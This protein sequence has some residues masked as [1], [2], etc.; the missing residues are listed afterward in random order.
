[1]MVEATVTDLRAQDAREDDPG[2]SEQLDA[3]RR[4]LEELAEEDR[5]P[6]EEELF[7]LGS[8]EGDQVKPGQTIKRAQ[9]V[10][11]TVS[12]SRAE[13]PLR[14]SGMLDPD[15]HGRVLVTYLPGKDERVPKRE[16]D[17]SDRVT[18]W[19]I[20]QNLRATYVQAANDAETMIRLFYEELLADDEKAAKKLLADLAGQES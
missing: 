14:G 11:L 8:L 15:K 10:E 6:T 13:V 19:K 12:L 18:G 1:M 4:S 2:F 16:D 17:D 3:E 9:P 7:P 5:E 20:R